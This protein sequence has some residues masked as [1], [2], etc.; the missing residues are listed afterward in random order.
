MK[1][2]EMGGV[3]KGKLPMLWMGG[4]QSDE[5]RDRGRELKIRSS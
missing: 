2:I 4:M 1:V 5:R 3:R